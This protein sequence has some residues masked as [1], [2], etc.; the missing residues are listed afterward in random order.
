MNKIKVGIVEDEILIGHGIAEALEQSG[1]SV[2]EP[3]V[4][5]TEALQ[6][7]SE[8]RPDIVILDINLGGKQDGI[9]LA[10]KIRKDFDIPFIF[11]TANADAVTV[12]RAKSVNPPAYLVKPFCKEEL[13]ASIEICLHNFQSAKKKSLDSN[14]YVLKD[15]LFIKQGQHFQKV[16]LGDI[17]FIESE[18]VYIHVHTGEKKI[19]VRNS[20]QNYLNI[21]NSP[22]FFR[23]HRSY[24][25]N[26]EHVDSINNEYVIVGKNQ[27]PIAKAQRE[28]FLRRLRLG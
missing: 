14:N 11:L 4:D 7:L 5:F 19:L 24:A 25:I 10:S 23:I 6:M 21:I 20:I 27:I 3:A 26:V 8:E 9:D 22:S 17:R 12:Q 13:F 18:N 1:Y 16:K 15:T 28:E 2:V